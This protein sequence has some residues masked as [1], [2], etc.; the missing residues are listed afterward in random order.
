MGE[1]VSCESSGSQF[2]TVLL[3]LPFPP[4]PPLRAEALAGAELI[5]Y[6]Q[7][8]ATVLV[9]YTMK[10]PLLTFPIV[11]IQPSRASLQKRRKCNFKYSWSIWRVS[12]LNI[13]LMN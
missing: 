10:P 9:E 13:L 1:K 12:G 11:D 4:S 3:L 5:E 6:G 7:E 8:V 2:P